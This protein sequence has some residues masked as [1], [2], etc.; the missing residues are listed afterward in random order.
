MPDLQMSDE[1]RQLLGPEGAARAAEVSLADGQCVHC[2]RPLDGTV[3]L[4]V[5]THGNFL[6]A[7]Y[8]HAAC[9]PSEIVE[10]PADEA[11]PVPADG[12]DMAM[13]AAVLDHGGA[14]LPVLVA[15]TVSKAY[16][17]NGGPAAELT[18]A[19]AAALLGQGFSLISRLRAAPPPV[20]EWVGVLLLGHG[21][22]GEDGLLVL[23]PDGGQ[24]YAGAVELPDGWLQHVGRY[25][26]AVLYV[27][28]VGLPE[29][30]GEGK[31]FARA[32]RAAAQ[33]GRLVGARIAV[34]TPPPTAAA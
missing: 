12:Y 9:G 21:P 25:G 4:V 23:D 20:A 7:V 26:W 15:E 6:H 19:V 1:V 27:G 10:L 32:L 33:A 5:R 34:G 30:R 18:S 28:D 16:L 2:H 11:P 17:V 3:H 13:T 29:L 24:F 14:D 8:V 22:A 31:A